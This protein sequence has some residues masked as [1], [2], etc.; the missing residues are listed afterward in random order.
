[1]VKPWTSWTCIRSV[2]AQEVLSYYCSPPSHRWIATNG[3][4]TRSLILPC[5]R[6]LVQFFHTKKKPWCI[7]INTFISSTVLDAKIKLPLS[8]LFHANHLLMPLAG[9]F[10]KYWFVHW[11]LFMNLWTTG[12]C[13]NLS[14]FNFHFLWY[15]DENRIIY[16]I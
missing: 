13:T 1:M 9:L 10:I 15:D 7:F 16:I 6:Y 12:S 2:R 3:R 8:L 4:T 14:E 11:L 5:F